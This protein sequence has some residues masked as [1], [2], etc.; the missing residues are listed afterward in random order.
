MKTAG[1]AGSGPA[2][3]QPA[4]GPMPRGSTNTAGLQNLKEPRELEQEASR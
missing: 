4:G 3:S 2:F 1:Q